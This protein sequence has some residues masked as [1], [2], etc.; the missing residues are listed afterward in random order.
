VGRSASLLFGESEDIRP[1]SKAYHLRKDGE[2]LPVLMHRQDILN[3]RHECIAHLYMVEDLSE[4]EQL[5]A[6]LLYAERL[7]LLG[8][9]AP[10]IAHEFKTPLQCIFGQ[11]ELAVEWLK[12]GRV[13]EALSAVESV[14]PS[15]RQMLDLVIQLTNL[16]KPKKSREDEV[17]LGVEFDRVLDALQHLGVIKYCRIVR[18]F[19]DPL[20]KIQG[21]PAQIEQ[22]FR[23][24]VV[25]SA[26]AMEG[27]RKPELTLSLKASSDG[28]RVQGTVEDTGSGISE[29]NLE[30]I[31][32]PFFSTKAE[33][34]GTGLGLPIIKTIME[35]HEGEITV[36]S[37][38]GKGT[39]F[40]LSF[41][42]L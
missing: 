22:V 32:Q 6:Q 7:S 8:Q 25:N 40:T 15:G 42:A 16:G 12:K 21:D 20:P 5:E 41:P 23:N 2:I 13:E 14:L 34:Q 29:E 35:S 39:R 3:E 31:F 1:S 27:T 26:Q 28:R 18:N 24:L 19:E 17:N 33:G 11:A 36:E 4:R 37:E 9:L 38:V 30:R 10:R